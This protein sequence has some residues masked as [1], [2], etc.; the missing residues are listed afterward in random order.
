MMQYRL[1][2]LVSNRYEL[3][4]KKTYNDFNFFFFECRSYSSE[5][6]NIV[7]YIIYWYSFEWFMFANLQSCI[8]NKTIWWK[9]VFYWLKDNISFIDL[10]CKKKKIDLY[11]L[12]FFWLFIFLN[13]L[14]TYMYTPLLPPLKKNP[15][16]TIELSVKNLNIFMLT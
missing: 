12:L 11:F 15:K 4:W 10:L 14:S 8:R 13:W 3:T 1:P 6:N 16:W 7:L 9:W 5:M 2:S